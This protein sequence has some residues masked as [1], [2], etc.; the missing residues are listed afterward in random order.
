MNW[1]ATYHHSH[2]ELPPHTYDSFFETPPANG[3]FRTI[4]AL[5]KDGGHLDLRIEWVAGR[6]MYA[7]AI[8][9]SN[10]K[11][12]YLGTVCVDR[13]DIH[14][15]P[16]SAYD[17]SEIHRWSRAVLRQFRKGPHDRLSVID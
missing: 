12:V 16:S 1:N 2:G 13:A 14:E 10:D 7:K 5:A 17:T 4:R 6:P 15:A 11:P 3:R 8:L 9:S